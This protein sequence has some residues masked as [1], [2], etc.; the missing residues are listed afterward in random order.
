MKNWTAI[1]GDITGPHL[2]NYQVYLLF[3]PVFWLTSVL[4]NV[5][6]ASW[7]NLLN[8]TIANVVA[9][10][11]G[12]VMVLLADRFVFPRRDLKPANLLG[13]LALG[14][15]IGA[16]KGS[17]TT[18]LAFL[19][20]SEPNLD[21]I[22]NRTI[23]ASILGLI[24]L[25]SLAVLAASQAK[26]Q[27][28]RDSLVAERVRMA[29]AEE[30]I[31]NRELD[32]LR[33]ELDS[34]I[35]DESQSKPLPPL[36]HEVVRLRLRPLTHKLWE[37]ENS[38]NADFSIKSLIRIAMVNH[39]FT[40][41]PVAIIISIGSFFPYLQTTN[42]NEALTRSL[43]TAA[44][45]AVTYLLARMLRPKSF[46]GAVTIFLGV[47]AAIALE[48]VILSSIAFGKLSGFPEFTSTLILFIWIT[49]TAFMTS[50]VKGVVV[51]RS[52]IRTELEGHSRQLGL[53]SDVLRARTLIANRSLA[54]HLHGSIQN[55]LLLLALKL[56]RG[57]DAQAIE[58][59]KQIRLLLDTRPA[60]SNQSAKEQILAL[61]DLWRG[62]VSIEVDLSEY[63][64]DEPDIVKIVSEAI[65]NSVRHG[66]AQSLT[67]K[68]SSRPH[69]TEILIEDD[70]IGPRAG[71]PGLGSKYFDSLA[72]GNWSLAQRS[73]GGAI[74]RIF[75][76]AKT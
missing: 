20:G 6:D 12:I 61:V 67:V 1:K 40:A 15:L 60:V 50:F 65:N 35:L 8:W 33:S 11:F 64:G 71:S 57:E 44:V 38:R 29:V 3:L 30:P 63:S 2:F 70:G 16:V 73:H 36:L 28:E 76:E 54:N 26:F 21:A 31:D 41:L 34:L 58:E 25:P 42:F 24:T 45:I 51:T 37:F 55:K 66:L 19:L 62:F 49:Q 32:E 18:Y 46:V 47:H 68:I 7:Q 69:G 5:R 9:I 23:Q 72:P 59:L 74:L 27:L 22:E 75:L 53:D 14:L 17:A 13:V 4:T 10:G 56:E 52:E 43:L 39:P 48:I